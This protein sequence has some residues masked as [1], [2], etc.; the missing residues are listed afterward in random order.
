MRHRGM[1]SDRARGIPPVVPREAFPSTS[2][3]IARTPTSVLFLLPW[4]RHW[5]IGTTDT[6]YSRIAFRAPSG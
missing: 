4:G 3:L 5:L 1:L 2:A 6:D